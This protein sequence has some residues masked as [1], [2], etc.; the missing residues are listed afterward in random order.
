MT[1]SAAIPLLGLL[2]SPL[3]VSA[4][5]GKSD[6]LKKQQSSAATVSPSK[7]SASSLSPDVLKGVVR[8]ALALVRSLD[9]QDSK[10]DEIAN[11]A[12]TSPFDVDHL[13]K[14]LQ[15]EVLTSLGR[16]QAKLGDLA[17]AHST[18][19]SALELI[20]QVQ[21]YNGVGDQAALYVAIAQAQNEGGDQAEAKFTLRQALQSVRAI[22]QGAS[23]FYLVPPPGAEYTND[24]VVK[25]ISLLCQ[26]GATQAKLGETRGSQDAFHLADES[27]GSISEAPKK[28]T[29]LLEIAKGCPAEESKVRWAQAL[30]F[31]L[32]LKDEYQRAGSIEMVLRARINSLM[33]DEALATLADRLQGDLRNYAIWVVADALASGEQAVA[34]AAM[35]RLD[36]LAMKAEFDRPSKKFK[37]FE[38]IAEAHARLGDH[39][40]A[41]R[42]GG[43][44]HPV[45]DIQEF[46]ATQARLRVMKAVA[47]SQLKA[48]HR[49][50]ARD[51]VLAALEL[52]GDLPDEDAEAYYP[53]EELGSIQARCG[54]TAGAEHTVDVLTSIPWRIHILSEIAAIHAEAG[55]KDLAQKMILRALSDARRAPNVA[56]WART[57]HQAGAIAALLEID[58]MFPS[59]YT[60]AI[61]QARI[62]DFDA[63]LKTVTDMGESNAVSW[64]RATTLQQIAEARLEAGDFPGALKAAG[65]IS[66][67]D[68]FNEPKS[69]LLERIAKR[70]S[71]QSDPVQVLGWIGQQKA[72]NGKLRAI[73]GLVSGII[74]RALSHDSRPTGTAEPTKPV[75]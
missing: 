64:N 73:R 22:K 23:P 26:I 20:P 53:L 62:G 56:I 1:R 67:P 57:D 27:A 11:A 16:A 58:P 13:S 54:D 35:T 21:T 9:K 71:A 48:K 14:E 70:Q 74:D 52:V 2:L 72:S 31:A 39:D 7:T 75:P 12:P 50:A 44:P 66:E 28:T 41:Y 24:P 30:D 42:M 40:G 49:G 46:R 36:Q 15:T 38:R 51:T 25:K 4:D 33:V 5:D 18:W 8:D 61:A 60:I 37:V 55:R 47:E 59:L 17:G 19:Q 69:E 68:P 45:N 29:A 65:L 34:S 10:G 6:A 43:E 63:A 32:G 3:L